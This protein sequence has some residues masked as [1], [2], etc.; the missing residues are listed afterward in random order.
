[1][2]EECL[3]VF[4]CHHGIYRFGQDLERPREAPA[5]V[6]PAKSPNFGFKKL[7]FWQIFSY[8]QGKNA[9]SLRLPGSSAF[10][11]VVII[12]NRGNPDRQ[13]DNRAHVIQQTE[14]V[15]LLEPL[16]LLEFLS[17]E[18]FGPLPLAP[19]Q[20]T[21]VENVQVRTHIWPHQP[22]QQPVVRYSNGERMLITLPQ[23]V[24]CLSLLHECLVDAPPRNGGK[25]L[26][27]LAPLNH[28]LDVALPPLIG[29]LLQI[30][31]TV[32][33]LIL[34]SVKQCLYVITSKDQFALV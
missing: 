33:L 5:K 6:F 3:D 14:C 22:N 9:P 20:G 25:F 17:G 13:E 29:E 19:A 7:I 30:M 31:R 16:F 11:F 4:D 12:I 1:M 24:V 23:V 8:L 10:V 32:A 2:T 28:G 21:A 26:E 15:R 18:R 34:V 27:I